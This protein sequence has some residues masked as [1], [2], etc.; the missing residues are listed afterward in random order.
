MIIVEAVCHHIAVSKSRY[1]SKRLTQKEMDD[2]VFFSASRIRNSA[3]FGEII[4]MI[5]YL[6]LLTLS[7]IE[8]KMF[9]PMALTIFFAIMGAFILSLTY[10]PMA[11]AQANTS[12]VFL[13]A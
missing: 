3:A 10:V 6:P 11:S 12:S 9:K 5:V 1:H 2:E 7:G 13:T 4:I 8:G